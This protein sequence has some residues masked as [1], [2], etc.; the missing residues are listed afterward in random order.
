MGRGWGS[1]SSQLIP[2]ADLH[3]SSKSYVS[4][5]GSPEDQKSGPSQ[6]VSLGIQ[7]MSPPKHW[8]A[9]FLGSSRNVSTPHGSLTVPGFDGSLA[10]SEPTQASAPCLQ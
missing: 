7:L 8:V 9:C 1:L 5:E 2:G 6:K 4:P 10:C 3:L